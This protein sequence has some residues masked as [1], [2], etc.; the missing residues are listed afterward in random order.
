MTKDE[1]LDQ[2]S[3]KAVTE[4]EHFRVPGYVILDKK[5]YLKLGGFGDKVD[6]GFC[7]LQVV[8]VDRKRRFIEVGSS[9]ENYGCI[10]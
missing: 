1:V 4:L 5:S 2:I 8:I 3:L 10:K 6:T 7:I 9:I